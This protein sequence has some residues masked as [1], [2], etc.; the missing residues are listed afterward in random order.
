MVVI[1]CN[2]FFYIRYGPNWDLGSTYTREAFLASSINVFKRK[3]ARAK[4]VKG[5]IIKI[6]SSFLEIKKKTLWTY[7]EFQHLCLFSASEIQV[8]DRNISEYI[9]RCFTGMAAHRGFSNMYIVSIC[10]YTKRQISIFF[11]FSQIK[12][13][14]S[15]CIAEKQLQSV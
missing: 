2:K 6:T 7:Q 8:S 4:K 3:Q 11:G 12:L 14:S 13:L 15:I 9:W 5:V 1:F 10:M